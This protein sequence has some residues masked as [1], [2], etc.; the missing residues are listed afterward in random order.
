MQLAHELLSFFNDGYND[1]SSFRPFSLMQFVEKN[2]EIVSGV[3]KI[4]HYCK[5]LEQE[6]LLDHM[7]R[8]GDHPFFGHHYYTNKRFYNPYL[9]IYGSYDL[10]VNGFS[11]VRERFKE[12][13]LA[14]SV[15]QQDDEYSIGSSFVY[16][17]DTIIT[18]R[19]CLEGH[20]SFKLLDFSGNS[21]PIEDIYFSIDTQLDL[22]VL[23]TSK[24]YFHSLPVHALP[25]KP[26]H[27]GNTPTDDVNII[28]A[29]SVVYF[30]VGKVLDDIITL[31]YPPIAGFESILIADK[32][33]INSVL[34]RSSIGQVLSEEKKYYGDIEYLLMN[35]KVKGGNSG[36]PVFDRKGRV[37]GIV[38]EI[39]AD[40]KN[41]ELIDKLGYGIIIPSR[42]IK[43]LLVAIQ[44]GDELAVKVKV[45]PVGEDSY[46]LA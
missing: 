36:G 26:E 43:D 31:G 23:K 37:I 7:G 6:G 39:S 11:A 34:L 20:K 24:N 5:K 9:S 46:K 8:T 35:A 10:L 19:H 18:A 13:C 41:P 1:G 16:N 21:I 33:S 44:N 27:I 30:G 17:H 14:I 22:A 40:F 3:Y 38:V 4:T 2:K 12:T 15:L 29:P 25:P 42:Y 32:S 28:G 45:Q